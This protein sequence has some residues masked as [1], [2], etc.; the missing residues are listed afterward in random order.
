MLTY[1]CD[2]NRLDSAQMERNKKMNKL[3]IAGLAVLVASAAQAE[4]VF[5]NIP[6][7]L[8]G[9]YPSLGYQATSTQEFGNKISLGG[10]DRLASSATVTLSSWA[11]KSD[12]ENSNIGTATHFDHSLTMNIYSA[13]AGNTVGGL[14]GTVT[15]TFSIQ[16][17]PEVY[18]FNG[19]AQN[20]TFDLSGLGF[21]LPETFIYGIAYNTQSHGYNPLGTAGP[22]NSLNYAL[23]DTSPTIGTDVDADDVFWNTSF[24]GFYTDGGAGGVGTFRQDTNW[25]GF[26]P[27]VQ[28]EAVPEPATMTILALGALVALKK[29]KSN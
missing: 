5:T 9:N 13:G 22:W 11:K 25:A 4:T 23:I 1:S 28:F 15:Q 20:V 19:I 12:P 18:G 8:A 24:G 29:R 7:S 14:L 16:Y 3:M 2:W 6:G 17:R 26:T 10:T 27:M 21:N